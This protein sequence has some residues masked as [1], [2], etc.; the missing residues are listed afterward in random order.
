MKKVAE[1]KKLDGS[2]KVKFAKERTEEFLTF[3]IWARAALKA[4]SLIFSSGS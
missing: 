2:K 1:T 4:P 3:M